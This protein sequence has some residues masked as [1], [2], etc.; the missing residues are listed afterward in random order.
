MNKFSSASSFCLSKVAE[1]LSSEVE[2]GLGLFVFVFVFVGMLVRDLSCVFVCIES[3][4]LELEV[5]VPSLEL[6]P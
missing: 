5:L 3:L 1:R 4:L 2:D 6:R